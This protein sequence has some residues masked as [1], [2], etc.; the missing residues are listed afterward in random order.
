M[1]IEPENSGEQQADA[2]DFSAPVK[3]I[4][5]LVV[6]P[7]FPKSALGEHVDIG[8]YTG[9]VVELVKDSLK[10]RSSEGTTRSFNA[11][12]LRR[13]YGPAA[14]PEPVEQTSPV[15]NNPPSPE[16][17]PPAPE[18]EVVAEP[19]F[20]KPVRKIADFVNRPDFPASTLGKHIEIGGYTGVVVDIVNRS[21]KVRSQAETTRSY[22]ADVLRKL[23]GKK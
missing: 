20:T 3:P 13:I 15:R 12:G 22:N 14:R 2:F 23:H 1:A 4:A 17:P 21:L 16:E 5:E 11:H 7:G 10:V 8:G 18:R 19:D 6:H 9:V